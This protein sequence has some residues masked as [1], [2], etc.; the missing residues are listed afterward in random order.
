MPYSQYVMDCSLAE[1]SP[2]HPGSHSQLMVDLHP[3][4]QMEYEDLIRQTNFLSSQETLNIGDFLFMSRIDALA[5]GGYLEGTPAPGM[6]GEFVCRLQ[7]AQSLVA[8]RFSWPC[9]ILHQPHPV[10]YGNNWDMGVWKKICRHHMGNLAGELDGVEDYRR[11]GSVWGLGGE[12]LQETTVHLNGTLFNR[13][14]VV[15]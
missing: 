2:N 4:Q 9:A 7:Y 6:D 8:T 13:E 11:Q 10:R 14:I 5:S 15:P 12:R 1:C 3:C